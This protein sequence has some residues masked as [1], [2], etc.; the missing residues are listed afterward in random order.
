MNVVL[1]P[2]DF[3]AAGEPV[4]GALHAAAQVFCEKEFGA[5][6]DFKY[7]ARCWAVL[8]TKPEDS[9]YFEV[10]GLLG[11]RNTFDVQLFHVIPLSLDKEGMV[12]THEAR[13]KMI[14]RARSWC[15]DALYLSG[16]SVL[17]YVDPKTERYW[18]RF[19]KQIKAEPANRISVVV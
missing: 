16:Q 17:V 10:M 8:A 14:D 4:D 3:N 6:R 2:L 5:K 12:L 18:R 13:D 9:A 7:Y 15:S 19:L 11:G 1:R